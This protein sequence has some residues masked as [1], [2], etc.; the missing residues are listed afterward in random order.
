MTISIGRGVP[1][2]WPLRSPDLTPYDFFVWS[3]VKDQVYKTKVSNVYQLGLKINAASCTITNEMPHREW[4]ELDN[5]I[6]YLFGIKDCHV[7]IC[8]WNLYPKNLRTWCVLIYIYWK[9]F[10][11]IVQIFKTKY[12]RA[13][14]LKMFL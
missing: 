2:S 13:P 4:S 8:K 9:L 11:P 1:L 5:R 6:D 7:E 12:F 14:C 10:K 3:F